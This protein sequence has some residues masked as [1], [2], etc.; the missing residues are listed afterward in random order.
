MMKIDEWDETKLSLLLNLIKSGGTPNTSRPDYYNGLIPFVTIEDMT[1]SNKKLQFTKKCLS[2]NGL[3]S[4]NAWLVPTGSILYSIYAT[5]G[6]PRINTIPVTTNQAI[7]ALINNPNKIEIDYLYYWLEYSRHRIINLSSQTTQKN[8]NKKVVEGITVNYPIKLQ[9]QSKISEILG[10]IDCAI[11]QTE[12]LIAKQERIKTGLIQDLLT[13][14]IDKQGIIRSEATHDFKDSQLGRIPVEWDIV[15][16][17]NLANTIDPQ[18]DH[19]TPAEVSDG[20]PYIGISDINNNRVI[21]FDKARKVS[22]NAFLKQKK[23]FQISNGDFIFGKIGTIG[24]PFRLP[25]NFDY[26]LSA[27]VILLRPFET[28]SFVYWWMASE[29]A[30]RL[31]KLEIHSTSQPAF[32]IQKMR[33]FLIPKPSKDERARIG[34]ILDEFEKNT[35]YE[36][37]VYQKLVSIKTALMQDLLTGEKRVTLLLKETE[38]TN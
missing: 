33:T 18:P 36:K 16:L 21:N 17:S 2:D 8:L 13:K 22:I 5:I 25:A 27:N 23:S 35:N 15:E 31:I 26:A 1:A 37:S 14:G 30:D 29:I 28:H 34:K 4:S 19:R 6:L 32:G 10:T 12:A 24:K 9:E 20:I 38:V 3:K 11:E 7:L